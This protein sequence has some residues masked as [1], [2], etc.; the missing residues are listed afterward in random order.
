MSWPKFII[1]MLVMASSVE[2]L[3]NDSENLFKAVSK[4]NEEITDFKI[5]FFLLGG[6]ILHEN[7]RSNGN[8]EELEQNA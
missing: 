4:L 2:K 3:H 7:N 1:F 6:K 5:K 8:Q